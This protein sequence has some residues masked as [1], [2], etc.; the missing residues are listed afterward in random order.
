[1]A[2]EQATITINPIRQGIL[3]MSLVGDSDLILCAKA[4]SYEQ[5][6]I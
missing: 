6:E 2:K 5:A 4:R 1:M 3:V